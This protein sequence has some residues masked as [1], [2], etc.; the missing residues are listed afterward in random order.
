M[1]N[2]KTLYWKSLWGQFNDASLL[3]G[4]LFYAC[5]TVLPMSF[6]FNAQ[7]S[8]GTDGFLENRIK[9]P[10]E[11]AAKDRNGSFFFTS[12]LASTYSL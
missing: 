12:S 2:E 1:S 10:G 5:Y 6:A 3:H 11:G 4:S 8:R 9:I 7:C